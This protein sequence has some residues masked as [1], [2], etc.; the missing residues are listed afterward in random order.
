[1]LKSNQGLTRLRLQ[2]RFQ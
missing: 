2:P 1:M